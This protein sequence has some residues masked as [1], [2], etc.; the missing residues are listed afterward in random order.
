MEES[1]IVS[2]VQTVRPSAIL[3]RPQNASSPLS[4]P[5]AQNRSNSDVKTPGLNPCFVFV[6]TGVC[7]NRACNFSHDP[8]VAR[9]AWRDLAEE[10][11]S[12]PY[13]DRSWAV[14]KSDLSSPAPVK[15]VQ[16][17]DDL[18]DE[19]IRQILAD[20]TPTRF[21]SRTESPSPGSGSSS[22]N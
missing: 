13:R 22:H 2:V 4:K 3:Q 19:T 15:V 17:V 11:M 10:I 12:S 8:S 6:R 16:L 20:E 18:D 14:K 9:R 5:I 1:G 21:V 7:G